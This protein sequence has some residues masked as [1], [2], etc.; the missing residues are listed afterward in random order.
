[1]EEWDKKKRRSCREKGRVLTKCAGRWGWKWRATDKT[2]MGIPVSKGKSPAQYGSK[3][4]VFVGDIRQYCQLKNKFLQQDS[5]MALK[6]AGSLLPQAF[7]R[8]PTYRASRQSRAPFFC[9][10]QNYSANGRPSTA[11]RNNRSP[12]QRWFETLT[13]DLNM[14][15]AFWHTVC[16]FQCIK[17]FT[18]VTNCLGSIFFLLSHN[19]Q[20]NAPTTHLHCS[21]YLILQSIVRKKITKCLTELW[22]LTEN[23]VDGKGL[24]YRTDDT[25]FKSRKG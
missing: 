6:Q 20:Q 4:N 19:L 3:G 13:S 15:W 10:P 25:K 24:G 21:N 17:L 16:V 22:S 12:L 5:A 1:M 9:W 11:E 8:V 23:S 2:A 14:K 18:D 7:P